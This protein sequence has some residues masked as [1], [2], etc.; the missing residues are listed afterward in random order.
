MYLCAIS[1]IKAVQ[2][3]HKPIIFLLLQP[4]SEEEGLVNEEM[5]IT[6]NYFQ[7]KFGD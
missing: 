6:G 1:K 4:A 5:E 7:I 3:F 2:A